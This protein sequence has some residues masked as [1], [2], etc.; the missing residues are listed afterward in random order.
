MPKL[1]LCFFF[2]G[3]YYAFHAENIATFLLL[4]NRFTAIQYPI[5]YK[6]VHIRFINCQNFDVLILIYN[7]YYFYD[8]N[9]AIIPLYDPLAILF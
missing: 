5:S 4:V 8:K 1:V 9:V 2:F 6:K 3:Y 7:L